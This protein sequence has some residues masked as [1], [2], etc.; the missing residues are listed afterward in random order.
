MAEEAVPGKNRAGQSHATLAA[1]PAAGWHGQQRLAWNRVDGREA[2]SR[3]GVV[4]EGHACPDG[5]TAGE[6]VAP[7]EEADGAGRTVVEGRA[8]SC[9]AHGEESG[10]KS[11][12]GE[13]SRGPTKV[14]FF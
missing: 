14:V 7:L 1:A 6:A 11:S 13:E 5:R 9:R 3:Q 4:G 12:S 2:E 8:V 10:G